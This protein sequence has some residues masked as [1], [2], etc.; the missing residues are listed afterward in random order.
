[1]SLRRLAL[2]LA[3]AL[4]ASVA[5]ADQVTLH[6]TGVNGVNDGH[7]YVSPYFATLNGSPITIF[8]V[9]YRNEVHW[10]QT[11]Q[12]NSTWLIPAGNLSNTRFGVLPGASTL[13]LQA[14][15]LASQM[16]THP[17]DLVNIQYAMWN[18][19]NPAQSPD[20]AGSAAWLG[21]A[22]ANYGNLHAP[23]GYGWVILTNTAP[24]TLVGSNQVQEFLALRPVPEPASLALFGTGL[25]GIATLVRR[26]MTAASAANEK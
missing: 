8:C 9:D 23:A 12:A 5:Q 22:A 19:F 21:M 17:G 15:W 10:G 4:C 13:Y 16:S 11:W 14:A 26:R 2:F 7:V 20:T 3:L 1:M 18:L 24:V 25:V 6:F